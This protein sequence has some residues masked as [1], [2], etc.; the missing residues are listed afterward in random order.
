MAR[1]TFDPGPRLIDGSDLN[2]NFD[3]PV[4][5]AANAITA[6]AGGGQTNG[7]ALVKTINRVTVVA[8]A[9]D[10]VKLP[11]SVAGMMVVVVNADSA[12]ALAVFPFLGDKINALAANAVLSVA[13]NKTIIFFCA[14]AG[15]WNS[16]L[17][18]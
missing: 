10:S 18:A 4:T 17:T 6:R 15:T 13:A 3:A 9:A 16:V 11:Q 2:N 14:V 1:V 12:D 5:S 8:T 7:T